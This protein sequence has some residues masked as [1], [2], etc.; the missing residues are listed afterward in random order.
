MRTSK[1]T[2]SEQ[3]QR[4][5]HVKGDGD[6]PEA[7]TDVADERQQRQQRRHLDK[8]AL[9]RRQLQARLVRVVRIVRP[10]RPLHR[11]SPLRCLRADTATAWSGSLKCAP[12]AWKALPHRC[13][14]E[15]VAFR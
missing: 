11:Q 4:G 1:V 6:V 5:A 12:Q 15:A 8:D 9:R 7:E 13:S 2:A 3:E 14:G 10:P